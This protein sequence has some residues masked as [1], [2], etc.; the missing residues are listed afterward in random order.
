MKHRERQTKT[1]QLIQLKL[2]TSNLN[3]CALICYEIRSLQKSFNR[4]KRLFRL[5]VT[6]KQRENFSFRKRNFFFCY[7][8][9]LIESFCAR[10][11]IISYL[12]FIYSSFFLFLIFFDSE[13]ERSSSLWCDENVQLRF[14]SKIWIKACV[15]RRSF[16]KWL[17]LFEENWKN[18]RSS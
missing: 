16:Q 18:N 8:W 5:D 4:F 6:W 9:S 10:N 11:L 17:E 1:F 14:R 3:N 15:I 12:L 13:T 2:R 7:S